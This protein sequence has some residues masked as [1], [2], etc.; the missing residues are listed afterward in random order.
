MVDENFPALSSSEKELRVTGSVD[1]V[2]AA[3]HAI[4]ERRYA[5]QATPVTLPLPHS[6]KH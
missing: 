2:C 1:T 6:L 4:P 3:P 5:K